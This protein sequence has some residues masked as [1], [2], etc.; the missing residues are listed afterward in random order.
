MGRE[1]ANAQQLRWPFSSIKLEIIAQVD[2][3]NVDLHREKQFAVES[4]PFYYRSSL[5]KDWFLQEYCLCV[6]IH[7]M[8]Q[9]IIFLKLQVYYCALWI[10]LCLFTFEMHRLN[11][12]KVHLS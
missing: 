1:N 10:M 8:R 7:C 12:M 3:Q 2:H 5:S 9:Q 4:A 6:K 11:R